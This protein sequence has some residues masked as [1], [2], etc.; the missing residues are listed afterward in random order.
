[1]ITRGQDGVD[2]R[3][4]VRDVEDVVNAMMDIRLDPIRLES[5]VVGAIKKSL[6]KRGIQYKTEVV[7][8]P[9]C[10]VDLLIDGGIVVEVKKGKPNSN[11]VMKQ[12]ERYSASDMV[13]A[14]ILV[15][16]RGLARHLDE[17]NGKPIKYI[18]LSKN[19]GFAI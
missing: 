19:W 7:I 9:R 1:M 11:T 2:S 18:A 6:T 8:G 10:R 16:E 15:S 13:K 12:V 14:V 5:D 17:A 3:T 4:Q